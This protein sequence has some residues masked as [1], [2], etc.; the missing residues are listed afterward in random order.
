M[1]QKLETIR[2]QGYAVDD[3]EAQMGLRCVAA[4][5]YNVLAEP[6]AAISV[7]G[8]TSRITDERLPEVGRIVRETAG[9][10]TAALGGVMPCAC[11]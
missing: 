11:M 8:M 1:N 9:E 10:L 2:K 6:L 4:V 7:S 5:V 3:E